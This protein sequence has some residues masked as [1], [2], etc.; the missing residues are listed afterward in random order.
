MIAHAISQQCHTYSFGR[1][2]TGSGVHR[3][4]HQW[5]ATDVPLLWAHY[6]VQ[7]LSLRKQR[8]LHNLWKIL[9]WLLRQH[10]GSYL[11][12]WVY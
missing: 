11:A 8:W 6:P 10:I 12:K 2:T 4:K 1:S 3:F 5:G 7:K 9:P